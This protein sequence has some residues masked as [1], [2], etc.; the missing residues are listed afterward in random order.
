MVGLISSRDFEYVCKTLSNIIVYG[1][2]FCK[3]HA[4]L[5]LYNNCLKCKTVTVSALVSDLSVP[6]NR[7]VFVGDRGIVPNVWGTINFS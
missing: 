6:I 5:S 3:G 7:V 1:H 4:L 2:I